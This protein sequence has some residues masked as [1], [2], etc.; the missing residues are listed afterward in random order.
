[1]P[2]PTKRS[3]IWPSLIGVAISV[4]LLALIL[5]QVDLAQ[6]GRN[7]KAAHPTPLA[8][9]VLLATLTF[10]IRTLRWRI[11]LRTA[12]GDPLPLIPA[13]HATAMGFMANNVLPFRPGELLRPF[14]VTRLAGVRF[15]S[16]LSSIAVE[17]IFDGL[18]ITALLTLS[19][20]GP[21]LPAQ[22]AI[23]GVSVRHLAVVAGSASAAALLVALAVL[24]WPL[25]AERAVRALVPATHLADR[26]VGLI[27]GIRQGLAA[28]NS[29][30]RVGGVVLWSL[31]LWLVIA[32]SF[33]V[34]F[35]AFDIPVSFTGALL[36]QGFLTVGVSLPFTPGYF[37]PFEAAIVAALA[38][39]GV[40]EDRAFSYAIA[41]H[42]TTFVPITLLGLWSVVRTPVRLRDLRATTP[43]SEPAG[44]P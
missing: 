23:A 4:G 16:A 22:V 38:L 15:T 27:E 26:I 20:L 39:Y 21:G 30:S 13:W 35:A 33:Y 40:V 41:Y 10:P 8:L 11:L 34:A 29:P 17:R 9:A 37:G 5:R 12:Q 2:S 14:A 6:V 18:T 28:L 1:L 3:R 24:A 43:A 44:P 42:V 32:L 19:L 7:L 36:L 25:A 31:A